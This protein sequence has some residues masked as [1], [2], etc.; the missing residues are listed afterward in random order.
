MQPEIFEELLQSHWNE[1]IWKPDNYNTGYGLQL[2]S[3]YS[4][5]YKIMNQNEKKPSKYNTE[6]CAFNEP[7]FTTFKARKSGLLMYCYFCVCVCPCV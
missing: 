6:A 2:K 4:E 5:A 7:L 3:A 1:K